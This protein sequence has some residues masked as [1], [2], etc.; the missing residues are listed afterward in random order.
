MAK[1]TKPFDYRTKAEELE[2]IVSALQN[3]GIQI[4][5]ATSLHATGLKLVSELEAYLRQAE[6]TV[7]KHVSDTA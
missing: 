4:D 1:Q 5:E 7:K 3:P 6:I 2:R